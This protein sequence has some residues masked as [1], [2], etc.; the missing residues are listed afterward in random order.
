MA[1]GTMNKKRTKN[2]T[3]K[4][5][6]PLKVFEFHGFSTNR[7]L[8]G[9]AVGDCPF[10]D[11]PDKM[12]VNI[13]NGKFDCKS[14]GIS[15]N[16]YSFLQL[17]YERALNEMRKSR[18]SKISKV[19]QNI[20]AEAFEQ[21]G[22][23][24]DS[25]NKDYLVP[26]SNDKGSMVNL[27]RWTGERG[28]PIIKT[29]TCKLHL[30]GLPFLQPTGPIYLVEGEWDCIALWWL[31]NK[32]HEESE[33]FS[34]LAS[35]GASVFKDEWIKFFLNRDVVIVGDNDEPGIRGLDKKVSVLHHHPLRSLK[36]VHWP[37]STPDGYD[38]E[39]LVASGIK[40]PNK[41]YKKLQKYIEPVAQ[42][43]GNAEDIEPIEDFNE[44]L[45]KYREHIHL[46][47]EMEDALAVMFATCFSIRDE[48]IPLW[49]F[50]VGPSGSG[51]TLLLQS[52]GNTHWTHFEGTLG[53]RTLVS[54]AK[55]EFDPSLLPSLIGRTLVVEDY[56]QTL[57][58]SSTDL[59]KLLGTLRMVYNGRYEVS[60]G[61]GVQ[62]VYPDPSSNFKTCYF[63][64]LCGVTHA[65]KKHE[66]AEYG[67][68]WLRFELKGVDIE[69]A[70]RRAFRN[71]KERVNAEFV[72]RPIANAFLA[73]KVDTSNLPI[74]T[75][76]IEDKLVGLAKIISYIRSRAER[77]QGRLIYRPVREVPTRL[78]M[79]LLR[80]G[81][82][83]AFVYGKDKVDDRCY[84]L[85]K[86]VALDTCDS[87]HRDCFIALME[88]PSGLEADEISLE[89][90][91]EKTQTHRCL[92]DL[93]DLGA[94]VRKRVKASG[95]RGQRPFIWRLSRDAKQAV[96]MSKLRE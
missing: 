24:Y 1:S 38:L 17:T 80:L 65:I 9:Q 16:K 61:N 82:Y 7:E 62:R 83:L 11:K 69:S 67:E 75:R 95:N 78:G 22:I 8:D 77:Y 12:F 85:V 2:Q 43:D 47:E 18:Y 93:R 88:N 46:S 40:A 90:G 66:K 36:A 48:Q 29:A 41:T 45:K 30:F 28:A 84:R 63:S 81:Q 54:G 3:Q 53:P 86:K 64:M 44:V 27:G 19:R 56:T 25:A 37:E 21:W 55:A 52:I 72:L 76:S 68:R 5:D 10:C 49:M 74:I 91:I 94:I 96:A 26:Y 73:R 59:D 71:I 87:W 32:I 39:D 57:T 35:P 70:M 14:C 89:G 33:P 15:G 79:Q 92:S 50:L 34:V 4:P 6:E 42:L 58:A 60:Y 31:L 13:E 51:K 23:V 20:P